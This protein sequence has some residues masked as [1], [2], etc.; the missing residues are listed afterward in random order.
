M[1]DEAGAAAQRLQANP[2][3][4]TGCTEGH[5]SQQ[6]AALPAAREGCRWRLLPSA[7][8]SALH[9]SWAGSSAHG[10]PAEVVVVEEVW[11]VCV[12]GVGGWGRG[13]RGALSWPQLQLHAGND[14]ARMRAG[15]HVMSRQ[16][17]GSRAGRRP[18]SLRSARTYCP[19]WRPFLLAQHSPLTPAGGCP[20]AA[21]C[22]PAA[23]PPSA[24]CLRGGKATRLKH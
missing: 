20:P 19:G 3:A 18:L 6:A 1:Q 22:R 23:S 13:A 17:S 10:A 12:G 15:R 7:P 21:A 24:A 2:S 8:R 14:G 4:G 11:F 16:E 9:G 5:E